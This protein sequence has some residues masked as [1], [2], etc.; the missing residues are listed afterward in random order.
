VQARSPYLDD[1][2]CWHSTRLTINDIFHVSR[3]RY[4]TIIYVF[5]SFPFPRYRFDAIVTVVLSRRNGYLAD[6]RFGRFAIVRLIGRIARLK[7]PR[8]PALS[9]CQPRPANVSA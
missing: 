6:W 9:F 7:S 5:S 2:F 3:K 8:L 4:S 1:G